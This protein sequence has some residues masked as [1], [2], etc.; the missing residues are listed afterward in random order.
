M[1]STCKKKHEINWPFSR[2]NESW[3]HVFIGSLHQ[4]SVAEKGMERG[5]N[6]SFANKSSSETLDEDSA[7]TN[8]VFES[9][10]CRSFRKEVIGPVAAVYSWVHDSFSTAVDSVVTE[11]SRSRGI[12]HW[13]LRSWTAEFTRKSWRQMFFMKNG[14]RYA[15]DGI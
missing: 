14:R 12:N 15:H 1:V 9:M 10:F 13:V 3:N 5:Q 2:L 11:T 4:T 7:N 6:N 8:Q